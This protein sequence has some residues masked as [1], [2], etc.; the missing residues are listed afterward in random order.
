MHRFPVRT[1]ALAFLLA[2]CG[3]PTAVVMGVSA[4]APAPTVVVRESPGPQWYVASGSRHQGFYRYR[5]YQSSHVYYDIDRR[6]Y[7]YPDAGGATWQMTATLPATLTIQEDDMVELDMANEQPYRYHTEVVGQYPPGPSR[8]H[9]KGNKDNRGK[10][11]GEKRD[12]KGHW[13]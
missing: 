2:S 10:G 11:P 4:T 12:N 5:Y 7:F 9:G 3:P 8:R 6:M 13:D 1:A